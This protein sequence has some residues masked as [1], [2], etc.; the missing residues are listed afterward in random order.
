MKNEKLLLDTDI[1]FSKKYRKYKR[2]DFAVTIISAFEL[3]EI[4]RRRYVEMINKGEKARAQGYINSLKAILTDI[5][6]KVIDVSVIDV[7]DAIKIMVER[8]VNP[9]DAVNAVVAMR[10]GRKVVSE[11]KDWERVKDLV[12]VIKP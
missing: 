10:T 12:E 9:G 8:D 6:D 7:L 11:D 3:V 1:L 4:T 5:V 2:I